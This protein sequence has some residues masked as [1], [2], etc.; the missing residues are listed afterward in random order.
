MID[1]VSGKQPL[2]QWG[3]C[4]AHASNARYLSLFPYWPDHSHSSVDPSWMN[5]LRWTVVELPSPSAV[6]TLPSN[7]RGE[8]LI[9]GWGAKIPHTWW[10]KNQ[11]IEKKKTRSNIAT[12]SKKTLK[13]AHVKNK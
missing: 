11:N 10:P 8:D 9:P 2:N 4:L 7:A 13:V 5:T 3:A 1:L 6:K 12:N